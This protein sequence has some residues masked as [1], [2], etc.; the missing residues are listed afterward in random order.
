MHLAAF[1]KALSAA[2]CHLPTPPVLSPVSSHLCLTTFPVA[3]LN[4]G[5]ISASQP[6]EAQTLVS[7]DQK[8]LLI[9]TEV[10]VMEPSRGLLQLLRCLRR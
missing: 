10:L 7:S 3:P 5:G 2:S 1:Q 9:A 6:S 8:A 4:P